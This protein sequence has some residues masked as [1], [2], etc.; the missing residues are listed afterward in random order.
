MECDAPVVVFDAN[1]LFPFHVSHILTFAAARRLVVARWTAEI[2]E[3]WLE[4]IATKYPADLESCRRRCNAMNRALPDAMV[5]G[6]EH[7]ISSISFPDPDDR[8]VIAAALET[9]ATGIVTRDRRHFTPAA[10]KPFDL[11]PVD[12]DDLLVGCHER[13]PDDCVQAVEAA[14]LALTRSCP[15]W[16]QYLD[17]LDAQ[18]LTNFVQRLR[19]WTPKPK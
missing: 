14:R 6:Y 7:R 11:V 18:G 10:L 12:P 8:H 3:E 17:T 13:F 5:T 2:Q 16:D 15:S 4:H 19:G 9:G 1:I